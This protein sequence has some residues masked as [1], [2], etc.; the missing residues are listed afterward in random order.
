MLVVGSNT[1]LRRSFNFTSWYDS[2]VRS[3]GPMGLPSPRQGNCSSVIGLIVDEGE[4]G[5]WKLLT[6]DEKQ[7][8]WTGPHYPNSST[9]F[10]SQVGIAYYLY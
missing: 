10:D 8:V 2:G 4:D 9:D 7:Y 6:G 3:N 1:V 5:L